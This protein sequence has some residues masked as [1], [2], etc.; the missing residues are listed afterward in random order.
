MYFQPQI[1]LVSEVV[2]ASRRSCAGSTRSAASLPPLEVV[3]DAASMALGRTEAD[4][5]PRFTR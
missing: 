1:D 4:S 5:T 3:A 2:S